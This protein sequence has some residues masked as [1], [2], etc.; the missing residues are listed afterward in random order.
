M[1]LNTRVGL[2]RKEEQGPTIQDLQ[3]EIKALREEIK[4]LQAKEPVVV[5]KLIQPA[6]R[7]FAF[8][9]RRDRNGNIE[10]IVATEE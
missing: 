4:R 1:K 7:K 8:D 3:A 2:A 10:K 6:K 5:E 9:V